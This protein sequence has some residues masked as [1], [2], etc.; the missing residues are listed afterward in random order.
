M[1]MTLVPKRW[2]SWDFS[3]TSGDRTLAVLDVSAWCERAE[4]VIGD[5][6]HRVF[7]EGAMSGDF[8]IA[9]GD[10]EL[11]RAAKPSVF[12]NTFV[13]HYDG[14]DYTL[15]KASV[16]RRAFVLLEGE[17]QIGSIAPESLWTRR[18]A[19]DL[20]PDWPMPIRAFLIWL[21]VVL[22]KREAAASAA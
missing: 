2:Y 3:V 1:N 19:A 8:V 4:I 20:P 9:R 12:R 15:R 17:R 14:T 21:A 18:A 22:W 11:A 10:H 6:T 7:R 16:W 13:V 5:V